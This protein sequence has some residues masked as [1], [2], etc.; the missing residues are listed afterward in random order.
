MAWQRRASRAGVPGI[1][2]SDTKGTVS[3]EILV[4]LTVSNDRPTLEDT[5][6]SHSETSVSDFEISR[7]VMEIRAGWSL[8]ERVR[9]RREAES[10]FADLMT[11]LGVELEAA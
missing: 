2:A 1:V 9:R 5:R 6:P 3:K 8:S 4:M 11:S 10:R 7:R